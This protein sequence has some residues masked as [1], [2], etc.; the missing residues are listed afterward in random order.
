MA[1]PFSALNLQNLQG[2][3]MRM[4]KR[5]RIVFYAATAFIFLAVFDR[6]V[7]GPS[8]TRMQEQEKEIAQKKFIIKKDLHIV[9]LKDSIEQESEKYE[10]YFS[11]TGSI[12]DEEQSILKE[13]ENLASEAKV[14]LVYI[15]PQEPVSEGPFQRILVDVSC[16]SKMPDVVKFLHSIENSSRL[17]TIEKYRIVPKEEGSSIAQCRMT[18]SKVVIP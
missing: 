10:T 13:V 12:D 8:L 14:Y 6:A 16:E 15:R 3:Y 7:I 9:T 5:E 17:L 4:S 2:V 1:N 11:K 18:V